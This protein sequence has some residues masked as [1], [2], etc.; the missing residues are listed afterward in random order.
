[1]PAILAMIWTPRFPYYT[2]NPPGG[3]QHDKVKGH[4]GETENDDK[5]ELARCRRSRER[6]NGD[7][8]LRRCQHRHRDRVD[9]DIERRLAT[10][11]RVL[12]LVSQLTHYHVQRD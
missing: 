3:Q 8:S 9:G 5:D 11:A 4:Y 7:Y 12:Y 1:M 6:D 2:D 10:V